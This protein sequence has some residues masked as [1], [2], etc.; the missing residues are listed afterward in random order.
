MGTIVS[1]DL[2]SGG[3]SPEEADAA[4]AAACASLHDADETFSTWKPGSPMSRVRRGEIAVD[5]APADVGSVL[6]T[7]RRAR[8]L[9]CGWFDPWAMP[10]GV[11]PT[12]LVKGW[13]AQRAAAIL[14]SRGMTAGMVN[15]AGDVACF[16]RPEAGRSVWRIGVVD[17]G[18]PLKIARTFDVVAAIA[19]SGTYERGEHVLDP[20]SGE[21]QKQAISATV[22]GPDLALADAFATA[23]VAEG[24]TGRGRL[25]GWRDYSAYVQRP[26]GTARR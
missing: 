11:D 19:T 8:E 16:G 23:Q 9:S 2:R 26:G 10:G 22:I 17:A 18:N 1:F 4:L 25:P 3:L 15:A 21:P 6:E 12:G 24:A 20:F 13:A 7:C 5:D 14:Q